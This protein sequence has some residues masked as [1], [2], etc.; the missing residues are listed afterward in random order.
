MIHDLREFKTL[1][2]LRFA[3]FATLIFGLAGPETA[4]ALPSNPQRPNDAQ[5]CDQAID[6]LHEDL[7]GSSLISEA[8]MAEVVI[9]A[10][11]K[12]IEMCGPDAARSIIIK[13]NF[14]YFK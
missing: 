6:R 9:L 10:T 2:R 13:F 14:G 3:L 8:E 4:G 1:Y 5:T 11:E 7:Q 12:T